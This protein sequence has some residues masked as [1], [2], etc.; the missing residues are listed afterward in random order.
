MG[1]ETGGGWEDPEMQ[2]AMDRQGKGDETKTDSG[3]DDEEVTAE[4]DIE[5]KQSTADAT[6]PD[7]AVSAPSTAGAEPGTAV[8]EK[9]VAEEESPEAQALRK[10]LQWKLYYLKLGGVQYDRMEQ[11][12]QRYNNPSTPYTKIRL[13][14]GQLNLAEDM[15]GDRRTTPEMLKEIGETLDKF[16]QPVSEEEARSSVGEGFMAEDERVHTVVTNVGRTRSR[17]VQSRLAPIQQELG[18]TETNDPR[19]LLTPNERGKL[20]Y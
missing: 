8:A 19:P 2:M 9:P 18:I 11:W 3:A 13:Y 14:I 7:Q 15:L 5:N 12:L 4:Q 17:E 16:M 10:D 1:V 6:S 20:Y